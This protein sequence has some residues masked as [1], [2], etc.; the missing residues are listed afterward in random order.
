MP[1]TASMAANVIHRRGPRAPGQDLP[2]V[3]NTRQRAEG[4]SVLNQSGEGGKRGHGHHLCEVGHEEHSTVA[5]TDD[6][7]EGVVYPQPSQAPQDATAAGP[8]VPETSSAWSQRRSSCSSLLLRWSR[9]IT[10][11]VAPNVPTVPPHTPAMLASS[12]CVPARSDAW[13]TIHDGSHRL[14]DCRSYVV[15][16]PRLPRLLVG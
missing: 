2:G 10:S 4:R 14:R 8:T 9:R 15:H 7:A 5:V 11:H 16:A 13:A 6:R 12:I 3:S 1:D